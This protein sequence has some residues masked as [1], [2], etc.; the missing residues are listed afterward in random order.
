MLLISVLVLMAGSLAFAETDAAYGAWVMEASDITV[1]VNDETVT[2]NPTLTLRLGMTEDLSKAYL[3]AEMRRSDE[4]LA[5]FWAEEEN[6]GPARYALSTGETCGSI[7]PGYYLHFIFIAN[8]LDED[9]DMSEVTQLP[10]ALNM[11]NAFLGDTEHLGQLPQTLGSVEIAGDG[12]Y[13]FS[14]EFEGMAVSA[15]LTLR[16]EPIADKPFD[17]SGLREVPFNARKGLFGTEGFTE[18]EE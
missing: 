6:N 15:T 11:A 7:E 4:I 18:A 9:A 12:A 2:L 14:A 1:T 16:W 3:S 17:L 13:R 10:N 5:G 8:F